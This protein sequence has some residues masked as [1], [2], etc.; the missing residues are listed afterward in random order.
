MKIRIAH[1]PD[2]DDAFMFYA[3]AKNKIDFAP[4]EF[5]HVLCDI[6]TLSDKAINSPE[7]DLS[8]ISYHA[9]AYADK[10]YDLMLSGASM[11]DNYGPMLV[12]KKDIDGEELLQK[13]KEG[14]ITV[15]V[16]GLLTSAYLSLK[17]YAPNAKVEAVPF[18]QILDKVQDRS[19]EAG[20]IIHEGQI[21]YEKQ[22]FKKL[23]NLG[24]WWFEKTGGLPLPLGTNVLKKSLPENVK[25]DLSRILRESIEY[26]LKHREE[27]IDYAMSYGRGLNN[28]E[29]DRFVGMYVND[30]TIDL[31]DRGKKAVQLF[32]KEA[33][34]LNLIPTLP[35]MEF[36]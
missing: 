16:P 11:G 6:Q 9:F 1:S 19:Y 5:E 17:L 30:I 32:L 3:L 10:N 27:A 25:K 34:Q 15:A 8:A 21:N 22:G 35:E 4:Y 26:S 20:L 31:G 18:D 24:E 14:I 13:I 29:A 36:V 23:V 28:D 7:F 12:Y 2:S 33:H